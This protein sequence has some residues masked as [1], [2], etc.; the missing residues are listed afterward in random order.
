[1]VAAAAVVW[2]FNIRQFMSG[3]R[4]DVPNLTLE[5]IAA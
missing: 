3:K 4:T 1:M 5:E 2:L